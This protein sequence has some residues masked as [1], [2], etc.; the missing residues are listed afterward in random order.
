MRGTTIEWARVLTRLDGDLASA[1]FLGVVSGGPL[2][3]E[4]E[5]TGDDGQTHVERFI[6]NE[7]E[8]LVTYDDRPP[9]GPEQAESLGL[10]GHVSRSA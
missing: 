4:V 3:V 8:F 7:G 9:I 1:V 2:E 5:W 6:L 10:Y